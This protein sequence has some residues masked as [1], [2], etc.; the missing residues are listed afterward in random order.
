MDKRF[1]QEE[2]TEAFQADRRKVL[3]MALGALV[4]FA[5]VRGANAQSLGLKGYLRTNWSQ[6]PH[7]YGSYSYV[8][9]AARQKDRRDLA[10][11][12]N[13]VVFFAGEAAHPD[14][15]STVHAAY[16]SGVMAA[17]DVLKTDAQTVAIIGAG[18]SGL[19]AAQML[20]ENDVEVTVFE[21][22]SRIGGRVWTSHDLGVPLDLGASWIHGTRGNPLT[23]LARDEGLALVPTDESFVIRGAGGRRIREADAPD[24]LEN[25]LSIQHNAGADSSQINMKAY[26]AQGEYGGEDVIFPDGYESMLP[27][28]SGSYQVRLAEPVRAVAHNREGV[29]IS[30]DA[31]DFEFDAVIVTLPLGVLKQGSV[32]F[33][34]AL[35]AQKQQA[36]KTLGMGTLDKL[37]LWFDD[38]FWDVETTW[39]ATPEN[40]LPQGQFNQWLNL[41]K[42]LDE[43]IIMAFNGGPS[44][45][46]LARLPDTQIAELAATALRA[47]YFE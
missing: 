11:D 21:S 22:R 45:L 23:A 5:P 1:D 28:L 25:V 34:P 19:A 9:Q 40:G 15:N 35:P 7:S 41:A 46:D 44:A 47:A 17:K 6:D 12:I 39:I 33:D 2:C 38:P 27:A 37:Y 14:H 8:P 18:V 4:A 13:E 29:V 36:I 31:Q 10:A 20:S 16:E 43:P 30:T 32:I 26:N 24:W 42:Y 3:T